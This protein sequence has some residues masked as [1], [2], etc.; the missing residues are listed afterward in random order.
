MSLWLPPAVS[1]ELAQET[2]IRQA[3]IEMASYVERTMAQWNPELQR[4]DPDLQLIKAKQTSDVPGMKPGFW[5]LLMV[6]KGVPTLIVL[7]DPLTGGFREPGSWMFDM[8]R[9]SDLWNG[10]AVRDRERRL[11]A[12]LRAKQRAKEAEDEERQTEI[13]ERY[14]AA[15]RAQVSMNR[16]APWSQNVQGRRGAKG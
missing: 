8:L 5:H 3:A 16:D 14:L 4:V 10:R 12:A 11:D 13:L 6:K 1:R 2:A 7:E 9:A 15:T